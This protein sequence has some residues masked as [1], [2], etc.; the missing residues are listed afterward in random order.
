MTIWD[1]Y[2][3]HLNIKLDD[4]KMHLAVRI[5]DRIGKLKGKDRLYI[6]SF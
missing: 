4:T 6:Y 3:Q 5:I 2:S 1:Y